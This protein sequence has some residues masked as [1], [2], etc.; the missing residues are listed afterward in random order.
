M[1][2][3]QYQQSFAEQNTLPGEDPGLYADII[4]WIRPDRFDSYSSWK[5]NGYRVIG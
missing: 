4:G 3:L 1:V 5:A 2:G